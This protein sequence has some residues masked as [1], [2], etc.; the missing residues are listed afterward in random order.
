MTHQPRPIQ[1]PHGRALN[2]EEQFW[3]EI[4]RGLMQI[5]RAI[6]KYKLAGIIPNDD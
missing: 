6:V 5:V 3:M 2:R 4:R 1:Q